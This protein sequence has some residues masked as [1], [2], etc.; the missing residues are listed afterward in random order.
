M[1]DEAAYRSDAGHDSLSPILGRRRIG[2]GPIGPATL[3]T[4]DQSRP[5][6]AKFDG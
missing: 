4:E 2:L 5:R 6:I 3:S 1:V